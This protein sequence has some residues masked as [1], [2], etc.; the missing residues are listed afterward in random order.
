MLSQAVAIESSKGTISSSGWGFTT[1]GILDPCRLT[2]M[3][4]TALAPVSRKALLGRTTTAR[5]PLQ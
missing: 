5:R 2:D 1:C 4:F 3:V